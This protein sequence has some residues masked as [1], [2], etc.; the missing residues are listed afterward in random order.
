[1]NL[2]VEHAWWKY[3]FVS[4][5]IH[6]AIAYIPVSINDQT[7]KDKTIEVLL[8]AESPLPPPLN[9]AVDLTGSMKQPSHHAQWQG[10]K[11]RS[12]QKK[13]S[14]NN[15]SAKP[16]KVNEK[17]DSSDAMTTLDERFIIKDRA[18]GGTGTDVAVM[19]GTSGGFGVGTGSKGLSGDSGNGIGKGG[20][21]TGSGSGIV[22]MGFGT[23]DGPKF[24][25]REIPEYPYIA[26]KYGKEG[27]VVLMVI[28]DAKGKLN[29]VEVIEASDQIFVDAAIEAVRRSKFLPAKQNGVYV[30]SRA[31][32]PIR[33]SLR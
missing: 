22:D 26:R 2:L 25:Y 20:A 23:P 13:E 15:L 5:L 30:P 4:M 32:L 8:V 24:Q 10:S 28:I 3:L 14:I 21:G 18:Q 33:F 27:M 12:Y 19:A 6:A 16:A 31:I 29:G 1:M 9:K 7:W 17:L 11:S